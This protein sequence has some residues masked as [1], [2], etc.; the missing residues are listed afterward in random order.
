ML[1]SPEQIR[2]RI[3]DETTSGGKVLLEKVVRRCTF[4]V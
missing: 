4:N 3:N 1:E 2:Y